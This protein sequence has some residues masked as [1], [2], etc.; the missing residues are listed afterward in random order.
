MATI[1]DVA[2]RAGVSV[3][4]VSAVTNETRFVAAETKAGV[5][6]AIAE[7]N[8]RRDGIARSLRRSQ[9]GTIGALISD[10]TN[11]FFSDLIKGVDHIVHKLPERGNVILCNT[12][13]DPLRERFYLDLLMEKRIDG[14]ILVPAGGNEAYFAALVARSFPLV[15]VDRTLPTVDSDSV[16]VD[17]L[18]AAT[19]VVRHLVERGD[20]RIAMLKAT[21]QATSI[22]DRIL[23]YQSV[24]QE[25][26]LAA[27][28]E[29][30]VESASDVDAALAARRRILDLDPLPDAIFCTNNFMTLGLTRV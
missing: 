21:L 20:R 15:L 9:T 2:S 14:L 19:E 27:L 24:M 1:R 26:G 28:P 23:G 4:T 6:E 10:I 17:K 13:E 25:A 11:P 18:G 16:L 8:Y 3:A 5:L 22:G 12:E 7:L 30:I 29:L